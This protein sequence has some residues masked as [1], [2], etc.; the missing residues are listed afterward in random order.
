M[1]DRPVATAEDQKW[2]IENDA[3]T[4]RE[5]EEIKAE[6]K[7]LKKAIAELQKQADAAQQAVATA[8]ATTGLKKAFTSS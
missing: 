8:N 3:R 6:P 4:L 1:G 5:A 7:R 2:E